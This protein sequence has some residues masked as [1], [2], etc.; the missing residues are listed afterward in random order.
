MVERQLCVPGIDDRNWSALTLGEQ[1]RQIEVEG[2]LLIP[3]LLS[4]EQIAKIKSQAATLETQ[5]MDHSEHRQVAGDVMFLG[6]E[7]ADLAA[8][9]TTIS[10][11][12]ALLGEDVIC[13]KGGYTNSHPG[14]LGLVIHTDADLAE[15]PVMIRVLYYLDDLTS[16]RSPFAVIPYSHL[17]MHAE[18]NPYKRYF[19]H[20][21]QVMVLAKAGSAI[22]I[23]HQVFHSNRANSSNE[24][25]EMVTYAYRPGWCEPGEEKAPWD[26]NKLDALPT[27]LESYSP[28]PIL[29]MPTIF[30][31]TGR[32]IW[33]VMRRG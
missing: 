22:L 5:G 18:G 23:N 16:K 28:T 24:H 13:I 17:S 6:G 26:Q 32:L 4:A 27:P 1:I 11:L 2:Y 25:R 8:H 21:D 9:P 19:H 31:A 29:T 12:R 3:D 14:H 33:T 10:F 7:I 20:S 30:E 15:P